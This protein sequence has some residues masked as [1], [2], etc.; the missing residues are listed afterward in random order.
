MLELN[1]EDGGQRRFILCSNTEATVKEPEKNLCRDVCA[2]RMRRVI[3]GYGGKPGYTLQQGGEFAYLQLDK[4]EPAD[5][6]FE[7]TQEQ[8]YLVLG[9]KRLNGIRAMPEGKLKWLGRLGDCDVL[10]CEEVNATTIKAL[11]AW[12]KETGAARLAVYSPRPVTMREQLAA[13]D[14]EANCYGL[15]D[16]L[17]R[18][19]G[20]T[21][22]QE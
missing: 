8:V 5:V 11:A 22:W 7:A 20:G 10:L 9:L 19:Q 14:I 3:N 2:E 15:L 18:G 16:V 17:L 6:P 4:L 13:L 1:A 21:V 12:P